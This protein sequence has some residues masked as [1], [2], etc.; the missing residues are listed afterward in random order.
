VRISLNY[1]LMRIIERIEG[2]G[3]KKIM[4]GVSCNKHYWA[5]H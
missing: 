4:V 3:N 2:E 5:I 1:T